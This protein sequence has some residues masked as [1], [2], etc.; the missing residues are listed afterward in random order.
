VEDEMRSRKLALCSFT[1]TGALFL[2]SCSSSQAP[3]NAANAPQTSDTQ[4]SA[5]DAYVYGFPM[6]VNYQTMYKQAI[7]TA[8]KDYRAPFN[9]LARSKGVATAD[10]TF[11]V[12]PNSDTPYSFLWMDLRAE[13][14]VIT[15][16]KI[17]KNRYYTA[18]LVDLYT[19][20]F[21]YFGSR[22][23]GNDGGTYLVAGPGW[24]GD[25]P[26][27]V[28]EVIHCETEFAYVL[29]RTQLFNSGDLPNVFKIQDGYRAV[30]LSTFLGGPAPPAAPGVAWIKPEAD[31]TTTPAIFRYVDFLLQFCPPNPVEKPLLARFAKLDIGAGATFDLA[32]FSAADQKAI[33]D[34]IAAAQQDLTGVMQKI[35]TDQI[36]S[37]EMFGTR[38]AL[39]GNYLYRYAGAKLGLYGNS[40]ADAVY[41]G[42]FVDGN[43]KQLNAAESNYTLHFA[44]GTLPDAKAFWSL[45]MYD[46]KSQLLVANPIHRY[47]LNS[48]M[49]KSFKWDA[50]D[51]LTLYIQKNSPGAALQ[52]NWLPAPDGPFYGVLRVYVPGKEVQDGR[53]KKPPMQPTAVH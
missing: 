18:Q 26:K 12:T 38:D 17:E 24:K 19:F 9:Q 25:K 2:V 16:P 43:G 47:L 35:N 27:G 31:M 36:S 22:T 53:W 3:S 13:P 46:G 1:V 32:K 52:P 29:F 44:K 7:D 41:L 49:V 6:V 11:V 4:Q 20:N 8:D 34:G 28:N 40:A 37:A 30:P 45:T 15:M 14:I 33:N 42:Y 21:A 39:A 10:D 48:T 51:G 5:K 50:D 23:Y